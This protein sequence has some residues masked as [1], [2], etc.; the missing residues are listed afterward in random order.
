MKVLKH[1]RQ[2]DSNPG[3]LVVEATCQ[4][5]LAA[6][7]SE[8]VSSLVPIHLIGANSQVWHAQST[9]SSVNL[10]RV[11]SV[12]KKVATTKQN[13]PKLQVLSYVIE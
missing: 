13:H 3:Y 8:P 9:K 12:T 7:D 5:C 11:L 10:G 2:L 6:N 4:T 1:W